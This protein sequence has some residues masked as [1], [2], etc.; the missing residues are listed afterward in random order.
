[1]FR[2]PQAATTAAQTA[3]AQSYYSYYPQYQY[4]Y[5]T[6][7]A[8][9]HAA[10]AA[11]SQ[12]TAATHAQATVA[13]SQRASF[14]VT[15]SP[16]TP[17]PV[18]ALQGATTAPATA[19][20]A[21]NQTTNNALDTS[22]IATLN[23]ALGSAGVDLRVRRLITAPIFFSLCGSVRP[24]KSPCNDTISTSPH[25]FQQP[26]Q[27]TFNGPMKIEVG[28]NLSNPCSTPRP[29]VQRC[30]LLERSTKSREYPKILSITSH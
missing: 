1:M 18:T 12:A 20:S 19:I 4:S 21:A 23:D 16:A 3:L 29:L 25:T 17:A 27:Y 30:G 24:K 9:Q 7:A 2:T 6:A 10:S 13:A 5:L 22:D 14:S 8:Q 28:N 26:V 15:P 11:H